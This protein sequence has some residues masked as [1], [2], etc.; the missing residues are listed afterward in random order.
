MS[1]SELPSSLRSLW[2]SLRLGYRAEPLLLVTGLVTTVA[3]AAPDALFAVG[4]KVFT[5]AVLDADQ[6][7]IMVAA[8]LLAFLATGSWLL[9]VA[10]RFPRACGR[11]SS[12]TTCPSAIPAPNAWCSTTCT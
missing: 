7:A 6:S 8:L 4:F 9:S 10:S 1:S 12:S 2:R 3:A 5:E 11:A